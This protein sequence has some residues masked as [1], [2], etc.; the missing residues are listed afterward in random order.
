[1]YFVLISLLY[2]KIVFKTRLLLVWLIMYWMNGLWFQRDQ[3]FL[4]CLHSTVTD[5]PTNPTIHWV[6]RGSV[7]LFKTSSVKPTAH[8]HVVPRVRNVCWVLHLIYHIMSWRGVVCNEALVLNY[9]MRLEVFTTEQIKQS[10]IWVMTQFRGT[11]FLWNVANC[12]PDYR[13]HKPEHV[14]ENWIS[15]SL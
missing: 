4:K 8:L 13:H 3:L 9:F 14:Q 7:P 5:G 2:V 15:S 11:I 12:L 6:L 10:V 1:M